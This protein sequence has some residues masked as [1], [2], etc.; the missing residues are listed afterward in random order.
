M[1]QTTLPKTPCLDIFQN[2]LQA[3]DLYFHYSQIPIAY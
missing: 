2:I 1:P 3:V